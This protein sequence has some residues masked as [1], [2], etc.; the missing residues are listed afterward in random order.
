MSNLNNKKKV[1]RNLAGSSGTVQDSALLLP[2]SVIMITP[3]SL[4]VKENFAITRMHALINH[5]AF[6]SIRKVKEKMNGNRSKE[7][8]LKF[9]TFL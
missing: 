7:I 2:E 8:H 3:S 6:S 9:V 1:V 5:A 4:T